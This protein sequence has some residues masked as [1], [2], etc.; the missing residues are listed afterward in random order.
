MILD[1]FHL[2]NGLITAIFKAPAAD[3][4]KWHHSYR[5]YYPS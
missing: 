3:S 4:G 2:G 1:H 5:F